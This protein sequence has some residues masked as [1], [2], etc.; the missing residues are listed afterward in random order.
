[1]SSKDLKITETLVRVTEMTH[2]TDSGTLNP[3]WK[4]NGKHRIIN[5]YN[6]T[7]IYT[8][9][10]DTFVTLIYMN[11]TIYGVIVEILYIYK[12]THTYIHPVPYIYLDN[13]QFQGC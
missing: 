1:M 7:D 12:Y 8:Y 13:L 11:N 6:H 5:I 9:R 2:D 4:R 10:T 3:L